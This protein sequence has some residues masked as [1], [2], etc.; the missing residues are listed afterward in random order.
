MGYKRNNIDMGVQ[1]TFVE[2]NNS[3]SAQLWCKSKQS[4][5]S[6]IVQG[7]TEIVNFSLTDLIFLVYDD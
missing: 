6:L 2:W 1:R 4:M 5:L 3:Y 7:V